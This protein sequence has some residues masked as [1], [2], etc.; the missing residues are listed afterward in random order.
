M[1]TGTGRLA[2]DEDARTRRHLEDRARPERQDVGACPALA[3]ILGQ[4]VEIV[5]W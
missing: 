5:G 1:G 3:H 2:R 4:A